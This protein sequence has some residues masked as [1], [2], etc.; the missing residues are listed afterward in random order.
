MQ[1]RKGAASTDRKPY[2]PNVGIMLVNRDGRVFVGKRID[3]T[4]AAR[5]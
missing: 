2:R 4:L 5:Q 1:S 3:Q